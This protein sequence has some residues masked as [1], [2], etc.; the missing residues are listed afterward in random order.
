[1]ELAT[2]QYGRGGKI[3]RF[4]GSRDCCPE[5]KSG[6]EAPLFS[7]ANEL[8]KA[9]PLLTLLSRFGSMVLQ[10]LNHSEDHLDSIK[11]KILSYGVT[12]NFRVLSTLP[13]ESTTSTCHAPSSCG[14]IIFEL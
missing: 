14:C 1:M 5:Q 2:H 11:K 10:H 6:A 13:S 4:I 12:S 3:N 8:Q 7:F 9:E